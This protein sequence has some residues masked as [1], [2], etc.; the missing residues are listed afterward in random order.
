M[1]RVKKGVH[2][3]K[4]RRNTLRKTKGYR[5]GRSNK[6]RQANEAIVHAGAYAFA[7]RRAKKNDF[8]RMWTVKIGAVLKEKGL[9]YSK[10][11]HVL[12]TKNI[13]LDRKILADLAQYYPDTFS[14]LF[15]IVAQ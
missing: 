12:K 8:R 6:E 11:I 7:H 10:F 15:H 3:L 1:A 5:F 4:N 9:S 2:A 14:R 13:L